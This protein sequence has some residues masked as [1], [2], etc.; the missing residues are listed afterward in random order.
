MGD[1]IANKAGMERYGPLEK[2]R[3]QNKPPCDGRR[4]LRRRTLPKDC[5]Q[6]FTCMRTP[7][8]FLCLKLRIFSLEWLAG[9]VGGRPMSSALGPVLAAIRLR[10]GASA[11]NSMMP[12]MAFFR[13]S[14]WHCHEFPLFLPQSRKPGSSRSSIRM[15]ASHSS[16]TSPSS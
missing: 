16:C 2:S 9:Y 1:A 3:R 12:C 7:A 10:S 13:P 14:A 6:E 15:W 8:Y 4:A 11:H 5:R